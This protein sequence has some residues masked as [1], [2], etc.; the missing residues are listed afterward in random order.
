MRQ[1]VREFYF[2]E[3]SKRGVRGAGTITG[4]VIDQQEL[5]QE[6]LLISHHHKQLV[7]DFEGFSEIVSELSTWRMKGGNTCSFICISYCS[8]ETPFVGGGRAESVSIDFSC[9]GIREDLGWETR[10]RGVALK[11]RQQC[12]G[13][14]P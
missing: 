10:S 6:L 5:S 12:L 11:R 13:A 1:L 3:G 9:C 8:R 2:R 4:T 7:H 14:P